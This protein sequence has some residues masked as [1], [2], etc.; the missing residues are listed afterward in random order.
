MVGVH[1]NEYWGSKEPANPHFHKYSVESELI[2][3]VHT[4]LSS[5][6]LR[7]NEDERSTEILMVSSL[8]CVGDAL[9]LFR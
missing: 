6:L 1:K 8:H 2:P 5:F 9:L 3:T 4:P 7:N